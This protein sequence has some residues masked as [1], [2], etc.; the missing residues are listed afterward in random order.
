[1]L[2]KDLL[3]SNNLEIQAEL[4]TIL[5]LEP[6]SIKINTIHTML[7][8]MMMLN[9][10]AISVRLNARRNIWIWVLIIWFPDYGHNYNTA[11]ISESPKQQNIYRGTPAPSP[12]QPQPIESATIASRQPP[13]YIQQDSYNIKQQQ[14]IYKQPIQE[15]YIDVSAIN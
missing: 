9:F 5:R 14:S 2:L 7:F 4:C 13:Q 6:I 12:Q 11:A 3:I 1:M 8:M 15:E 10:I